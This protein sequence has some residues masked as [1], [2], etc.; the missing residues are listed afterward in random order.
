MMRKDG[1]LSEET[2]EESDQLLTASSFSLVLKCFPLSI[3]DCCEKKGGRKSLRQ[4]G[5]HKLR[6]KGPIAAP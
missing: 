2:P 1:E 6:P 5:N 4:A 3:D